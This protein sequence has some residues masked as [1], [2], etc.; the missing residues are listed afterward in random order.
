MMLYQ[1]L[2]FGVKKCTQI[3]AFCSSGARTKA[4]ITKC[5][6]DLE[7]SLSLRSTKWYITHANSMHLSENIAFQSWPIIAKLCTFKQ[8]YWLN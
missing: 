8:L 5:G 2:F 7:S 3:T 1:R 6:Y 4:D